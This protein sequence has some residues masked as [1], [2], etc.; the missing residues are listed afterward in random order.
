MPGSMIKGERNYVE[1]A[2]F[3]GISQD[4][5]RIVKLDF[6]DGRYFS[7]NEMHDGSEQIILGYKLAESLFEGKSGVGTRVKAFG[8]YFT[9]CG[10]LKKEGKSL[11]DMM[12][13]DEAAFLPWNT[14]SKIISIHKYANWGTMLNVKAAKGVDLDELKLEIASIL[15]PVRGL[16]PLNPDNF[17]INQITMLTNLISKIFG[18]MNTAGFMIG[19]F[20]MLVGAFGVANIMFV[21]VKERTPM[22]GIKM[23]LGARRVYILQEYLLEAIILCLVG[24]V[25]GLALVQIVMFVLTKAMDF[26]MYVSWSNIL[27]GLSLAVIIGLIAGIAPALQ[28]SRMDPVEA[29]RKN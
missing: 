29:I 23:A 10:I 20:A 21:S 25:A 26:E 13:T 16:K 8:K 18:V 24:G 7:P 17:A 3:A 15:R 2:Y 1:G 19:M 22:I 27:T 11:I 9:V 14:M 5:D 12:P 6:E 28:A 4:Y